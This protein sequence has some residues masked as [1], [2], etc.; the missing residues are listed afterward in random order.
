MTVQL[1][2][3]NF[4]VMPEISVSYMTGVYKKE[5]THFNLDPLFEEAAILVVMYQ[6]AGSSIIQRLLKTNYIRAAKII[7]QMETLGIIGVFRG[8]QP[9]EVHYKNLKSLEKLFI[10]KSII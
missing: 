4:N 7:D 9:R 8:D 5:D 3:S 10:E 2:N 1:S 6:I